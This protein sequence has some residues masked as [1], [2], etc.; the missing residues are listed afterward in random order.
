MSNFFCGWNPGHVILL[1]LF[2]SNFHSGVCCV[3]FG[4]RGRFTID[5][6]AWSTRSVGSDFFV[7]RQFFQR[8]GRQVIL[9]E[10]HA[11]V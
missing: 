6:F 7:G 2:P 1:V 9:A 5:P 4:W 10:I 11:F 8:L 3:T